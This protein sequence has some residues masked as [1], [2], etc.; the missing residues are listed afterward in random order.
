MKEVTEFYLND[1]LIKRVNSSLRLMKGD[2]INIES[3]SYIL[4][5][6][7]FSVDSGFYAN[8]YILRQNVDLIKF[9]A[10]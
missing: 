6:V 10:N 9:E 1:K 3:V 4:S 8:D 5:S 7:T 2:L